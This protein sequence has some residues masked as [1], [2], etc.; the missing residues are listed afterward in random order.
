MSRTPGRPR[1]EVGE[2]VNHPSEGSGRIQAVSYK[3]EDF[4]YRVK[5]D[6]GRESMH[7]EADLHHEP[8]PPHSP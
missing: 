1:Y 5:W 4:H 2:R 7:T 3:D 6:V 8:L